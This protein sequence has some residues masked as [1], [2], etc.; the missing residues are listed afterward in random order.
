MML[1]SLD[2]LHVFVTVVQAGS[3]SAAARQLR[4]APSAVSYAI[5][6]LEDALDVA[7]FDRSGHRAR[8]TDAGGVMAGTAHEVLARAR[9]ME[10]Q[11]AR[12]KQGWEAELGL[13]VD[14][15]LDMA[16]LLRAIARFTQAEAPTRLE[17][18]VAYL[19]GVSH[20]FGR[21]PAQLMVLLD[22]TGSPDLVARALPPLEM[23]LVTHPDHDLARPGMRSR[24]DLAPF[25]ELV[26]PDSGPTPVP[27]RL[28]LGG[29]RVLQLSDFS[30]KRQ[31]LLT[32][33]GFGWLPRHLCRADLEQGRLQAMEFEEGNAFSLAPHL[34]HRR[35][36]ALGRGAA[37]LVDLLLQEVGVDS[38]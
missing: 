37:L 21:D 35:D 2:Q 28:S 13:V 9:E 6:E 36:V 11:A 38:A 4:R 12:L 18:A 1:G 10:I 26:V 31:A 29:N 33:I 20:R 23:V 27:H 32:G 8:L 17:L 3:F 24:T 16:P 19:S 5:R 25:V 7:L 14:G 34:V 22:F 30:T 15:A